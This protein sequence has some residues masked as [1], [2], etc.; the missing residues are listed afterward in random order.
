MRAEL[1][2]T[3]RRRGMGRSTRGGS[4]LLVEVFL[5]EGDSDAALAEAR[6]GGC[7]ATVWMQLAR[8]R[9]KDHPCDAA[10]IYRESI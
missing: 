10:A 7:T 8:A 3:D 4:T 2:H 6:S 1:K 9:E 5:H